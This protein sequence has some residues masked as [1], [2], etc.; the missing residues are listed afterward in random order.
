M[1]PSDN[2]CAVKNLYIVFELANYNQWSVSQSVKLRAKH[3]LTTPNIISN[4][5]NMVMHRFTTRM[6]LTILF[7]MKSK[8]IVLKCT[9]AVNITIIVIMDR[10]MAK[11]PDIMEPFRV[12]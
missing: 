9:R 3:T 4:D 8:M 12:D 6:I 7:G 11:V 5:I 2:D 1:E 10:M